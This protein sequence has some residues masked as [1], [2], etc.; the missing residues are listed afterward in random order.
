[1]T[2]AGDYVF[3]RNT[4]FLVDSPQ[5]V[6]QAIMTRLS[7]YV[8]DWFLDNRLGL[9]KSLILGY[10]TQGTR[11]AQIK[12]QILAT[13]GVR[14]LVNYSSKVDPLRNFTVS[15]LVDTIYGQVTVTRNF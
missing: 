2:P 4:T 8:G 10:A 13:P 6:A 3:G 7:L 9:D 1:M 5:S 12:E 11:D 15:A 14:S